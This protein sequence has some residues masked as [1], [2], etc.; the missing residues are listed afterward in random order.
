MAAC[1]TKCHGI[2]SRAISAR[3]LRS[4][5]VRLGERLA[6]WHERRRQREELAAMPDYLLKDMGVTRED[7]YREIRKPFWQA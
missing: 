5:L 4:A 7:L 1:A 2:P 3:G 6:R